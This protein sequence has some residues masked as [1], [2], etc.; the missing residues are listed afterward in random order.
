MSAVSTGLGVFME[1]LW[2]NIKW[3]QHGGA[4]CVRIMQ[5]FLNNKQ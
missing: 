2:S 1:G 5:D 4:R 3:M